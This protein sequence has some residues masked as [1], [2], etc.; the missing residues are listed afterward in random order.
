VLAD[1]SAWIWSRRAP[2]GVREAFDE[3]VVDGL[4]GTCDMV[5]L[6]LLYSARNPADFRELEAE[7]AE[8]PDCPIGKAEWRSA[9]DVY[10]ALADSGGTH[11]RAVKHADLLIAA[12]ARA[13]G[14]EVLHYDEDFDRIAGITGQ[15]C[16]WLAPRG[17]L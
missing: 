9:L 7:L 16:R 11:H 4:I 15:A 17:T 10:R 1:T 2:A 12:A 3:A 8:L 14:S 5:R 13:A 6:E